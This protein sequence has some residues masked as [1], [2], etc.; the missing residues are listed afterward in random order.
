MFDAG[1]RSNRIVPD[2]CQME[3]KE[4]QMH[5]EHTYDARPCGLV[6]DGTT[7]YV[8]L[9][10]VSTGVC[11]WI[12][13]VEGIR[14]WA[15]VFRALLIAL[16]IGSLWHVSVSHRKALAERLKTAMPI[17]TKEPTDIFVVVGFSM[18]ELCL[19]L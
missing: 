4:A 6:Y 16:P 13:V 19:V 1:S 10:G 18:T 5:R 12:V 7:E 15:A 14:A 3:D 2:V 11:L 17:K 9:Q 8:L